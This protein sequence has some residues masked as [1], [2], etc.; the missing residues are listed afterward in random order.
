LIVDAILKM[1]AYQ[2]T[3]NFIMSLDNLADEEFI[4]LK[5]TLQA[6]RGRG[7]IKAEV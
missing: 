6:Q 1:T 7:A 4:A 3:M 2:A 5:K